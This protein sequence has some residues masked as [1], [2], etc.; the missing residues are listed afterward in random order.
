[1]ITVPERITRATDRDYRIEKIL[2]ELM[3]VIQYDVLLIIT[4]INEVKFA[5]TTLMF[6]IHTRDFVEYFMYDVNPV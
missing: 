1:M 5:M 4:G 3:R 2:T 6:Y